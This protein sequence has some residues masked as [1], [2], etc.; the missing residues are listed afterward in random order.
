MVNNKDNYAAVKVDIIF[1][2]LK[3]NGSWKTLKRKKIN[4]IKKNQINLQRLKCN[5]FVNQYQKQS[6]ETSAR[7]KFVIHIKTILIKI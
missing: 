1:V 3:L 4:E 5:Y 2:T 6:F 7:D